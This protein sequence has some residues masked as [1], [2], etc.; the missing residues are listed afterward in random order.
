LDLEG[1][2]EYIAT[3]LKMAGAEDVGKIFPKKVIKAIHQYSEG[4]PRMINILADN[5]LLLGYS[6]G[7]KKIL[8][9]MVEEC[10]EDL[11]LNGSFPKIPA[12]KSESGK[13]QKMESLQI[14]RHWKW[15]AVS[16]FMI[17]ISAFAMSRYGKTF[18]GRLAVLIPVS[19]QT[20]PDN[21][22]NERILIR[23]KTNQKIPNLVEKESSVIQ[24]E[25]VF[26]IAHKELNKQE[27]ILP[28]E[29]E[30]PESP[31]QVEDKEPMEKTV[32]IKEGDCLSELAGTVYGHLDENILNLLHKH[33]P[34]IENM[35]LIVAGQKI[36]FPPLPESNNGP[37]Y[38]V[39]IASYK[40]FEYAQDLFQ[41]LLR[42]GYEA[43]IIP[44]YN[45]QKG[46]FFKVTLG[47]FKSA[48]E[49]ED[50]ASEILKNNLSDY[51]KAVRME[52]R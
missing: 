44:V 9:S 46:K 40:P 17:A 21:L 51:A 2:Q 3:R 32:V 18:F 33:N 11:Q 39:H 45:T 34:E 36:I 24:K 48:L 30:E 4:Y 22:S 13:T 7:K 1:T 49:A 37:C 8:P 31:V 28:K 23:E 15:V 41:G 12:P 10:Y 19:Y 52:M 25:T 35:N 38:T 27:D 47:N 5:V 50:Y 20:V 6:S 29:P 43:Y 26:E 16:I 14:S 42:E